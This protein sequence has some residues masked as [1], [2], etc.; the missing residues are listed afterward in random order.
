LAG[1]AKANEELMRQ[2][3]VNMLWAGSDLEEK[4]VNCIVEMQSIE[5]AMNHISDE[6]VIEMR[7]AAGIKIETQEFLSPISKMYLP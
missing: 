5:G 1:N 6:E 3:G 4:R 2:T 7:E